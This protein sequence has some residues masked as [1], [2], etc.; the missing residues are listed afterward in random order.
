RVLLAGGLALAVLSGVAWFALLAVSISDTSSFGETAWTLATETQFGAAWMLRLAFAVVIAVSL[1]RP[2]VGSAPRWRTVVVLGA[3]TAFAG[4]L[5]WSGHGAATP[6]GAGT[7]HTAAD[8]LHAIAA[9]VWLGGLLP[10]ALLLG[11]EGRN[12]DLRLSLLVTVVRRF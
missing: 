4:T 6:G 11:R 5:A 10:L 12:D 3:A 7:V 9:A 8:A 1:A 2:S